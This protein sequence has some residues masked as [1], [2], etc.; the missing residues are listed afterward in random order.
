MRPTT[1]LERTR[2]LRRRS[3][4]RGLLIG[5]AVWPVTL[6]LSGCGRQELG[7][8]VPAGATVLVLGDS[9]AVGVGAPPHQA[10]PQL[11]AQQTGWNVV[12]GGV[13]GD[14]SA[15]A[16]QRLPQL[17]AGHRPA[18]VIVSIGGNDFLR[19][20]PATRTRAQID[21]IVQ[22]CQQAG[23]QVLL[24]GVPGLNVLAAAG[25]LRDHPL[26]DEIAEER[27]VPLLADAWSVVLA[28]EDLRSDQVHGN[29]QGYA[30]FTQKLLEGLRSAG[31]L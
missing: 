27:G 20:V 31:M 7:Q 23:A 13:S 26:Y 5:A 22:L 19:R 30:L 9:L 16:L 2:P 6:W 21:Q 17:L 29:A 28:S 10:F 14:T 24:V 3:V 1:P 12:N 18:L 4:V 8:R 15:Q 25:V 11:L